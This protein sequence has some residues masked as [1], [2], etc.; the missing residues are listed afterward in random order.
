MGKRLF[1]HSDLNAQ[2]QK[3]KYA[4]FH[5]AQKARLSLPAKRLVDHGNA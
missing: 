3:T 2:P 5:Q 1:K 4:P